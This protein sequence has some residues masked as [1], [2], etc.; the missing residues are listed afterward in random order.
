M[1][2]SGQPIKLGLP[3]LSDSEREKIATEFSEGSERLKNLLLKMWSNNI[4]T[5]ACCVGHGGKSKAYLFFDVR[6]FP[7]NK[8]SLILKKSMELYKKDVVELT[9][10][11]NYEKEELFD[12]KG[13]SIYRKDETISTDD[14]FNI[15]DE[16]LFGE[17]ISICV[18]FSKEEKEVINSVFKL[19]EVDM[20]AYINKSKNRPSHKYGHI[21]IDTFDK[22]FYTM[23]LNNENRIQYNF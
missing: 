22:K 8:L 20:D 17:N 1:K 5:Y 19:Y 9:F 16:I 21:E 4:E 6:N 11:N 7:Q 10:S 2:N 12:R 23:V 15:I 13:L 14:F 18:Q 3:N